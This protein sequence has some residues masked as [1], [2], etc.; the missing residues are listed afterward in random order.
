MKRKF[1]MQYFVNNQSRMCQILQ[2][3]GE[4]HDAQIA[5]ALRA[6]FIEVT[7]AE[8][9]AF[10]AET[11]RARDAGW[12][13]DG[14]IGYAKFMANLAAKFLEISRGEFEASV[15][16]RMKESGFLEVEIRVECLG[17]SGDGYSDSSVDTY[18]HY[19]QESRAVITIAMPEP[20]MPDISAQESLDMDPDEY[21]AIE[22]RHG[23]QFSAWR[24]CFQAVQ[25][26]GLKVVS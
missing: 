26:T 8:Q 18:W 13:P 7:P 3:R 11:L 1:N 20:K 19:W 4:L 6:G 10:R 2:G 5:E 15:I 9:E 16:K 22:A 14:R 24:K 25:A 17:R 23:A 21:E 12:N